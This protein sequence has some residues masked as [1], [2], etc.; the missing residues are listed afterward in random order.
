MKS[1]LLT[2]FMGSMISSG[3]GAVVV[4][5]VVVVAAVVSGSEQTVLHALIDKIGKVAVYYGYCRLHP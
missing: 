1:S 3:S 2:V 4:V 5:V